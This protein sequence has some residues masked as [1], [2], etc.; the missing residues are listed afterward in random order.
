MGETLQ[1]KRVTSHFKRE[2]EAAFIFT[3]LSLLST[4]KPNQTQFNQSMVI[5]CC[6]LLVFKTQAGFANLKSCTKKLLY[7]A[8]FPLY[9]VGIIHSKKKHKKV[10]DG[11]FYDKL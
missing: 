10:I 8:Y 5:I 3:L 1:K 7:N 11:N 2:R 6:I 4:L 9:Y